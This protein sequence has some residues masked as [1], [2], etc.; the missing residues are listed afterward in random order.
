MAQETRDVYMN[1]VQQRIF[2]AGA[3]DVRVVAARRF[4]KTDGVLGP[5]IWAVADSMPQGAG[6]FLGASR[7]QLFSR[8]IPGVIAAIERFYGFKEG[9]HFGWGKPPKSVPQC[10]IRPKSYENAMWFANGH[11][12]HSLSLATI[13]RAHGGE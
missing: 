8:T 7:K 10:I 5:R 12:I 9:I 6:A 2:Y 11:L 4:G 3:R 13:G 1:P